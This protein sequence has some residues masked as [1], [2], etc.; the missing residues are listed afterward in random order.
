MPPSTKP[1][2][3]LTQGD[4][5]DLCGWTVLKEARGL[6][7][8]NAVAEC[9]WE[10]P[11]LRGRVEISTESYFPKFNL[12]S[13]I[14]AENQCNCTRGR[15]GS[16]CSH[17]IALC[18]SRMEERRQAQRAEKE[19]ERL[20]REAEVRKPAVRSLVLSNEKGLPLAFEVFLP[21]NLPAVAERDAIVV[22]VEAIVQGERI[23]PEK[24]DRGRAYQLSDPH[25]LVAAI[26]ENWCDGQLHGLLQLSRTRVRRLLEPLVSEPVVFWINAR[27]RPL[28]WDTNQIPGVHRFLEEDTQSENS[29]GATSPDDKVASG[30]KKSQSASHTTTELARQTFAAAEARAHAASRHMPESTQRYPSLT[31]LR[32]DRTP[33]TAGERMQVDGSTHFLAITLPSREAAEY[34]DAVNLVKSNRFQLE[35]RN[36]KWWLRDRRRTLEFLARHWTI[37]VEQFKAEFTESFQERTAKLSFAEIQTR[38]ED[39][40]GGEDFAVTVGLRADGVDPDE[41]RKT[42]LQGH[43]FLETG[44]GVVLLN[45]DTLSRLERIQRGLSGQVD[46]P[47]TP[48]FRRRLPVASLADA[49]NLLEE[50]SGSFEAPKRWSERSGALRSMKALQ[51]A[52]VRK[53]LD[54][55]LRGYQ[56]IG[57]AWMWHLSCNRLGGILADEMGLGKTVQAL[58][59]ISVVCN[60]EEEL[61]G[62]CLVVCPAGLVENWKREAG[63]FVPWLRVFGHHRATRLTQPAEFQSFDLIVTSYSTLA[64]DADLMS[65]ISFAAVVA[66]EAQHV[67]NRQTRNAKALRGLQAERRFVLTGTPV[68]NTLDDLRSIFDFLMP[69]YLQRVPAHCGREDRAWFDL[70]HRQQA[71]PYIL[72]RSKSLVAPELPEKLEQVVFCDMSARQSALYSD[73]HRKTQ[74]E[75]STMQISGAGENAIR[76]AALQKLLRLRQICADPRLLDES[77]L[78]EDSAKLTTFLELLDEAMDGGHRVLLFSQFVSVLSLIR[79]TLEE[80]DLPYAYL[81]GQTINRLEVCDRFNS[82]PSI[83]LFLISLRA[84]GTGLNL[85]GADTVVH[86]DPWWNPAVEAQATD[87]AHRIGQTRSVTSLKLITAGSVEEKVL[88]LQKKKAAILRDLLDESAASTARVGLGEIMALLG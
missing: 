5:V 74:E 47:L 32:E 30:E 77:L 34:K 23:T 2:P 80:R 20:R 19:K 38:A 78:L 48:T 25:F 79:E 72:R 50:E 60:S 44:D 37:L 35:P 66:D 27:D 53:A 41:V 31:D 3:T 57:A 7:R 36:R 12:R 49:E 86:Y 24:L 75:I 15:Q 55:R 70:R 56:R 4:L 69:G 9:V 76:F 18:L 39:G 67:K 8:R 82:D 81:D 10:A 45:P 71:A 73:F 61:S 58:A 42:L 6:L 59:L 40:D 17:A 1:F 46:R 13:T 14:F 84:G 62:P 54:D 16:V 26:I 52:P 64:R 43:N 22:K 63:T 87:R 88:A 33:A 65:E 85:T 21:P 11:I 68:E 51:S 29:P 83:P 28:D